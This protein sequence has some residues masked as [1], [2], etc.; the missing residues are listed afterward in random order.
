MAYALTE[1]MKGKSPGD[2][3]SDPDPQRHRSLGQWV[4]DNPV[5]T[6]IGSIPALGSGFY[7]SRRLTD[8]GNPAGFFHPETVLPAELKLNGIEDPV[9]FFKKL[10]FGDRR[11]FGPVE[12]MTVTGVKKASVPIAKGAKKIYTPAAAGFMKL[13]R[14]IRP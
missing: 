2:V 11:V 6:G 12:N 5:K 7:A 4:I 10:F 8:V 14:K 1:L 9:D 13:F 3:P